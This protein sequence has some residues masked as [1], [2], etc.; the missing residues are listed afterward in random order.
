MG[1]KSS[2]TQVEKKDDPLTDI[3]ASAANSY[4]ARDQSKETNAFANFN[5]EHKIEEPIGS[6]P[7]PHANTMQGLQNASSSNTSSSSSDE[8]EDEEDDEGKTKRKTKAQKKAESTTEDWGGKLS[9]PIRD[10]CINALYNHAGGQTVF[11]QKVS[12]LKHTSETPSYQV[13]ND[14]VS[15][16]N[17]E[18]TDAMSGGFQLSAFMVASLDANKGHAGGYVLTPE[19]VASKSFRFSTIKPFFVL[20]PC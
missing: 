9:A 15:C 6:T 12:L 5:Q 2:K 14:F 19:Q 17:I 13:T 10:N 11:L 20:H 18:E 16:L 8:D 7:P 1:C 4:D 3:Y